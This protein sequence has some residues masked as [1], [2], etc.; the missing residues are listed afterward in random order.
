MHGDFGRRRRRMHWETGTAQKLAS[1]IATLLLVATA[2]WAEP[3]RW[4]SAITAAIDR[5]FAKV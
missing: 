1:T 2:V 3:S 4:D 5:S